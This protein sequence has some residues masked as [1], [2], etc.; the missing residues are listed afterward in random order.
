MAKRPDK[1]VATGRTRLEPGDQCNDAGHRWRS[2]HRQA[3]GAPEH[4]IL[5]GGP[6]CL[7][8]DVKVTDEERMSLLIEQVEGWA[9]AESVK[10]WATRAMRGRRPSPRPNHG[11]LSRLWD[12]GAAIREGADP[13]WVVGDESVETAVSVARQWWLSAGDVA[14]WL[15]GRCWRPGAARYLAWEGVRPRALLDHDGRPLLVNLGGGE[16]V[17]LG[18]AL[19]AKDLTASEAVAWLLARPDT[20]PVIVTL[21]G[22]RWRLTVEGV[23]ETS[24]RRLDHVQVAALRMWPR[25]QRQRVR[26][27]ENVRPPADTVSRLQRIRA[28][29]DHQARSSGE[30]RPA[31][32]ALVAGELSAAAMELRGQGVSVPDAMWL[33]SRAAG[34]PPVADALGLIVSTRPV[35]VA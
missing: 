13:G 30:E 28:L 11:A 22:S 4:G 7:S 15:R 20:W 5:A 3:N 1:P 34:P 31:L 2:R 35:L 8:G 14:G 26:L 10:W 27:I 6:A 12:L 17:P 21:E 19:S 9:A 18:W 24:T 23:G 16:R 32:E 29:R 33:L 25:T